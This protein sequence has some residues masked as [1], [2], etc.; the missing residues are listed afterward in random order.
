MAERGFSD[1]ADLKADE[2]VV[3][4]GVSDPR[5][6]VSAADL[7]EAY[8]D[9]R[10][11]AAVQSDFL[12]SAKGNHNVLFHVMDGPVPFSPVPLPVLIADM[13]DHDGPREDAAAAALIRQ[14]R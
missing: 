10:D 3:P 6:G 5:A 12:L 13:A 11:L 14:L 1:L 8:V 2:R 9:R 4:S 7:V